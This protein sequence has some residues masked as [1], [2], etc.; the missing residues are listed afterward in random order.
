L[1]ALPSTTLACLTLS[2]A[3]QYLTI[4][5]IYVVVSVCQLEAE[6]KRRV[7][8]S[9]G[10]LLRYLE[11]LIDFWGCATPIHVLLWQ[12]EPLSAAR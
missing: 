4:L 10:A 3:L 6:Y 2:M 8:L 9:G 7:H 12:Y 5:T 11:S 1:L